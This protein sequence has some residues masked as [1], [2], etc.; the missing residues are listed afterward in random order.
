[1][2]FSITNAMSGNFII[3][4]KAI[5]L[6]RTSKQGDMGTFNMRTI[7]LKR[8]NKNIKFTIKRYFCFSITKY[9]FVDGK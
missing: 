3:E 8:T 1:M 5:N 2:A 6:R 7:Q 9:C 4:R